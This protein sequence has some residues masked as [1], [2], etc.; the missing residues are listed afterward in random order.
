MCSDAHSI[1]L[2]VSSYFESVRPSVEQSTFCL[3][4]HEF[5]YMYLLFFFQDELDEFDFSPIEKD[6]T[7]NNNKQGVKH[8]LCGLGGKR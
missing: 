2:N 6:S 5:Y 3:Y 1:T 4:A 7:L 8:L